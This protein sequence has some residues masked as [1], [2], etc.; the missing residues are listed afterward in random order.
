MTLIPFVDDSRLVALIGDPRTTRLRWQDRAACVELG[1]SGDSYFP[2]DDETPSVKALAACATC[3]VAQEC[4]ATALIHESQEG[5][6][7]GW[8]GGCSPDER[9]TLARRMDLRTTPAETGPRRP[10]DLA[11]ILRA[12][13]RTVPSIAAELG[14]TQR[15]VYRYLASTAA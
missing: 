7:F 8:W 9:E 6:R 4:L 10:A 5:L 11:R 3:S 12:Q 1:L 2:E 14:C 15:T 13:N